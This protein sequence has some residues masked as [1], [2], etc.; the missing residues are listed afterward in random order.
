TKLLGLVDCKVLT[1]CV[2]HPQCRGGLAEVADTTERLVQFVELALLQQQF[3][4]RESG[5]CGVVEVEL[6]ELLPACKTLGDRAEVGKQTAEPT[7]VYVRLTD[8]G[9]LLCEH[10]LSLLLGAHEEDR[11][12]ASYGLLDEVVCLVN[13]AQ[14]L[15]EVDDVD[16]AALSKN[17]A[18]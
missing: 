12:T 11:A 4:L 15:L 6:F 18:L 17:E 8:A 5:R 10:F 9:C 2:N 7:L 3:F 14:R 13:V 1:L 16:P